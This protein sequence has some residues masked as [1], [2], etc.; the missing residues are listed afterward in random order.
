MNQKGNHSERVGSDEIS[1]KELVFRLKKPFKYLISKWYI[2]V[3]TGIIGGLMGFLFAK[4]K[5]S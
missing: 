1:I 4:N 2:L 3:I 5:L